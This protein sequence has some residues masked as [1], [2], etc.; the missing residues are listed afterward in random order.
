MNLPVR[1]LNHAYAHRDCEANRPLWDALSLGF[2]HL[3]ADAY[4]GIRQV[5]VAHDL[6]QLRPRRTL[7]NLYLKPLS[8]L[9]QPLFDSHQSLWLFVDVKTV[10]QSS[11]H[12]LKHTLT[13]YTDMLTC[14]C[15]TS[16]KEK[17]LTI[18]VSGNRVPYDILKSDPMRYLALD[19]RIED[20][21]IHTDCSVMPI[22]SDDWRRHFSWLGAGT[23]PKAE[24]KKLERWLDICHSHQQKLRFWNTPDLPSPERTNLWTTLLNLGID[25]INTDDMVGLATFLRGR[26]RDDN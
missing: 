24:Q 5:F 9:Q 2:R 16:T 22:I 11:Y 26:N 21:G 23:M 25:L 6:V 1:P 15:E 13:P 3:E 14:F 7:T 12:I 20:I 19:G 10:A 17:R 18:I 8:N 4:C